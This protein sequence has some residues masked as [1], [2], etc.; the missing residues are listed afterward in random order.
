M[1]KIFK[2]FLTLTVVA[3]ISLQ[4]MAETTVQ[5]QVL[6]Q[7]KPTSRRTEQLILECVKAEVEKCLE[8]Q[9]VKGFTYKTTNGGFSERK[10]IN[11][12]VS[13][14]ELKSLLAATVGE[15]VFP[16]SH[17]VKDAVGALAL[18][19]LVMVVAIFF[20]I[21]WATLPLAVGYAALSVVA[22]PVALIAGVFRNVGVEFKEKRWEK[23]LKEA[24]EGKEIK[25]PLRIRKSGSFSV[26]ISKL[27][28]NR[29][30]NTE[31]TVTE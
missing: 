9:L 20:P 3:T 25:R 5:S 4:S 19:A 1:K 27:T 14:D 21:F 26:L 18:P 15:D 2:R 11:K 6:A 13:P 22:F 28:D 24:T 23:M 29:D 7:F 16:R 10:V 12:N 30:L 8:Y 31:E 17:P